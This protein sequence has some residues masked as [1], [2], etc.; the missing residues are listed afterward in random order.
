M[1][2][3]VKQED[4][5]D[6]LPSDNTY[7]EVKVTAEAEGVSAS[8]YSNVIQYSTGYLK[9]TQDPDDKSYYICT[10][11]SG[12]MGASIEIPATHKGDEP[13][14]AS[15]P[16]KEI[17]TGAFM[18][19][20]LSEIILP[21][22]IQK[23]GVSAFRNCP[24]L[25]SIT[26]PASVT[27]I[28]DSAFRYSNLTSVTFQS[29]SKLVSIG[30]YAFESTDITSL[31]LPS[32]LTAIGESAFYKCESLNASITIPASVTSMGDTVF[33]SSAVKSV[34]MR[35]CGV[36]SLGRR[37]F[38]GCK[39]LT[40]LQLPSQLQRIESEAVSGCAKL[41]SIIIPESVIWMGIKAFS[42]CTGTIKF[43]DKAHD[44]STTNSYGWFYTSETSV[45]TQL[46]EGENCTH[47]EDM[48]SK[49][50]TEHF[51]LYN[52]FKVTQ[53]PAP[54]IEIEN[55]ILTITDTS[56]LSDVFNVYIGGELQRIIYTDN[57]IPS[58]TWVANSTLTNPGEFAEVFA[59]MYFTINT[60]T[61]GIFDCHR[62]EFDSTNV[63]PLKYLYYDSREGRTY[64]LAV[65]T[66]NGWLLED[67]RTI[68][69]TKPV[70]VFA[71]FFDWF[72]ANFTKQS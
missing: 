21:D 36:T 44:V 1:A 51:I 52:L 17:G 27:H 37:A 2:T 63:S 39:N 71:D 25:S 10:G 62:M 14:A 49:A 13:G 34:N 33:A 20:S 72:K 58:G 30:K 19:S 24:N 32:K 26:I 38:Y 46:L 40:S 9:F 28:G 43:E 67:Y 47:I 7:T 61:G 66:Q 4:I 65:Y 11:A 54:T 41:T 64:S 12:Y 55:G 48:F 6:L 56:N 42:G 29:G 45:P 23:I 59:S 5:N 31:S 35:S 57:V 3:L 18:D 22:S 8:P 15:L 69:I 53:V 68:V 60:T 16:V 50:L 70:R